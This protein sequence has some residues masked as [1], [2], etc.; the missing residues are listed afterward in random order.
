MQYVGG[1]VWG[2]TVAAQGGEDLP[3]QIYH[4]IFLSYAFGKLEAG[5][6][7]WRRA[8]MR[9]FSGMSVQLGIKNVF[10]TWPPFDAGFSF[11][12][13]PYGDP[14]LR[15]YSVSLRKEF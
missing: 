14:R 6:G 8:G 7:A 1:A 13:S 5:E 12:T 2:S 4:D 10:N 9:L 15:T 3:S 11:Y